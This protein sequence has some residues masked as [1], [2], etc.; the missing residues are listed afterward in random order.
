MKCCACGKDIEEFDEEAILDVPFGSE[1][2][3][4]CSEKCKNESCDGI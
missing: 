4:F 1:I 2:V 3:H